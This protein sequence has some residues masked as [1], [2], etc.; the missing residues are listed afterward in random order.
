VS[1]SGFGPRWGSLVIVWVASTLSGGCGCEGDPTLDAS[2]AV[3]GGASDARDGATLDA[4][5][6][7]DTGVLDVGEDVG[8]LD[9]EA[10]SDTGADSD[11]GHAAM[12]AG[13]D[14][15]DAGSDAAM[16]AGSD[17]AMDAGSD[18]AM[19][20]GSDAGSDVGMDAG[21]D[22]GVGPIDPCTP[23]PS[24]LMTRTESDSASVGTPDTYFISVTPGAPFCASITGSGGSWTVNVSNGTSS[25]IYC[26]GS[27]TCSITVPAGQTT[28]LVTAVTDDI[29]FYTLTL[30]YR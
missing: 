9:A 13:S 23:L 15:M 27:D 7:L 21:R 1:V 25:G 4:V 26:S 29:G 5:V 18:A 17:A 8:S 12:D 11:A 14:T 28:L 3:D 10:D 16:D 20:A 2:L 6:V 19:D 30:R 24:G 22:A